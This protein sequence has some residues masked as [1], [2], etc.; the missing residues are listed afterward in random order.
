MDD[1]PRSPPP[2][3]LK[4]K[5]PDISALNI[6][7]ISIHN[8]IAN[9]SHQFNLD[10]LLISN[11]P[12]EE[13]KNKNVIDFTPSDNKNKISSFKYMTLSDKIADINTVVSSKSNLEDNEMNS[14]FIVL[15]DLINKF[16]D[17]LTKLEDKKISK[18][19]NSTMKRLFQKN[20]EMSELKRKEIR[21][22]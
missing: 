4:L 9:D 19:S 13:Y 16:E 14:L 2:E 3:E 22:A 17:H 1:C 10:D 15:K 12:S 11:K 7:D 5:M 8:S 20:K 18:S 6:K 21:R